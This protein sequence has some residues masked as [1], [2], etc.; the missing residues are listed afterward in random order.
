MSNIQIYYYVLKLIT[1]CVV[2]CF[3]T[4]LSIC[5]LFFHVFLMEVSIFIPNRYPHIA[6]FMDLG[7]IES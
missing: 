5:D 2:L 1:T 6:Y 3:A 4:L 7:R